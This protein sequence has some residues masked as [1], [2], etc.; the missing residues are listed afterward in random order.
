MIYCSFYHRLNE[1]RHLVP[2]TERIKIKRKS[3][4]KNAANLYNTMPTI[5]INDYNNITDE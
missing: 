5:Y 4:Y 2:R 3:V 1:F